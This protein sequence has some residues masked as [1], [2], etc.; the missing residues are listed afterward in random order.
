[1]ITMTLVIDAAGV[2]YI[3]RYSIV[4]T[5]KVLQFVYGSRSYEFIAKTSEVHTQ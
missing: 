2:F 3:H 4:N 5:E 1:M